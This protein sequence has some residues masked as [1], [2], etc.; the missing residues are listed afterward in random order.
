MGT[1]RVGVKVAGALDEGQVDSIPGGRKH[2]P[3]NNRGGGN[4]FA[5][6]RENDHALPA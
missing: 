2:P 1:H 3:K 4:S 5:D 6:A